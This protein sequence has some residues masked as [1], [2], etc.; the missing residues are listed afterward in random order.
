M[1]TCINK[2]KSL[3]LEYGNSH[4]LN[5]MPGGFYFLGKDK[6]D[7]K[8]SI[9]DRLL[10]LLEDYLNENRISNLLLAEIELLIQQYKQEL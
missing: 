1:R 9:K 2:I 7:V 5:L 8:D 6:N 4:D 3:F 10:P